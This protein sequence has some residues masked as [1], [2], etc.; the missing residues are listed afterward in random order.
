M[1]R[2]AHAERPSTNCCAALVPRSTGNMRPMN[3]ANET[4]S[5][6]VPRLESTYSMVIVLI[7]SPTAIFCTRSMPLVT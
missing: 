6:M 3:A 7:L 2:N 1:P 5:A 4:T